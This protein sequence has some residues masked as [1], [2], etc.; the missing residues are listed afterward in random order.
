MPIKKQLRFTAASALLGLALASGL[1]AQGEPDSRVLRGPVI[2]LVDDE[3]AGIRPILGIPG[4][5]TLGPALLARTGLASVALAPDHDYVLAI[6]TE[7]RQVVIVS[8]L[9]TA[10]NAAVLD[11]PA[12]PSRIV[13]SPSGDAAALFYA[14]TARVAA[15]TGLPGSP[16]ISWTLDLAG[17]QGGLTALAISDGGG[18]VLVAASGEPAPVWMAA[19]KEG[20]RFLYAASASPSLTFF[21]Q[22]RRRRDC[23]CRHRRSAAG[24]RSER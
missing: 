11:V 22:E 15:I 14:D 12:D 10:P 8:N 9:S 23:R 20:Q 18:A 6:L 5:A 13:F 17:M 3:T 7:G 24:A 19:S 16:A 4:A 21:F 1:C 2:G